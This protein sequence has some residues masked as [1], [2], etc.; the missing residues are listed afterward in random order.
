L[1]ANGLTPRSDGLTFERSDFD[2][3]GVHTSAQGAFQVAT[4]LFEFIESDPSA[5]H[6][7]FSKPR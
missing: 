7:F 1:W 4:K 3:D 2:A 5:Q 6:W